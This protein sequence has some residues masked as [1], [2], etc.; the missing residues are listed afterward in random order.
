MTTDIHEISGK[1]TNIH[2]VS[3]KFTNIHEVSERDENDDFH[4]KIKKEVKING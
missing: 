4:D 3:G 2:E 1:F